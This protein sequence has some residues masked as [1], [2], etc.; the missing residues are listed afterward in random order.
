M[1]VGAQRFYLL[2]LCRA[3]VV[4]VVVGVT[5]KRAV[6]LQSAEGGPAI[7]GVSGWRL[8]EG[9]TEAYDW[10]RVGSPMR[11][12]NE[13]SERDR[14]WASGQCRLSVVGW[15]LDLWSS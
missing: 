5:N 7:G 14:N 4:V 8:E 9:A 13:V 6:A 15:L 11:P 10:L 12:P 3:V 1:A 2:R